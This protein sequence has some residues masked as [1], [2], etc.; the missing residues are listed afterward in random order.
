MKKAIW[1]LAVALMFS[2]SVPATH[3][4]QPKSDF[5]QIY[6]PGGDLS[7]TC[8]AVFNIGTLSKAAFVLYITMTNR[9]EADLDFPNLSIGGVDGFVRVQNM[10]NA[11]VQDDVIDYAI[12][13]GTTLQITLAGGSSFDVDQIY[14]VS[15]F[16]GANL[17]GQVS[18]ITDKGR[19]HPG[20][21][22][23]GGVFFCT[24]N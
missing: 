16:G 8:G 1:F 15:A 10:T 12:P 4:L 21:P 24:D 6:V 18:L 23:N 11:F 22:G 9:P 17:V 2:W 3:A 14:R 7:A 19:P 13:V 20:V 5:D